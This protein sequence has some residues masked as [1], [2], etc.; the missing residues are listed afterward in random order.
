M[1]FREM[2]TWLVRRGGWPAATLALVLALAVGAPGFG[3]ASAPNPLWTERAAPVAPLPK[4]A[5]IWAEI[6]AAVMPA[7]V[8]VST[9]RRVE[10]RPAPE[11]RG[12]RDEQLEEFFERFFGRREGFPTP[13]PPREGRSLGSGFILHP[14]GY[15]VTNHH[16][17]DGAAAIR[18]T[19]GDGRELPATVVGRDPQT[20]LT[21]LRVEASD[22]PV[23]PLGES[24]RLRVGEPV[25]AIGNPFGLEQTVTTGIVSATGRVIGGGPYD[26]FIQT[27][28]SI[29]PG[30]SGGPLI[31]ARGEA[32]G[33]NSAIFSRTGGSVGIGFAIPVDLA[34]P[35]LTQLAEKGR[36][37]RSQLGV[38]IQQLT[39]DLARAFGVDAR[40]GA[41]VSSVAEGSPAERAGVKPGDVILEY[42][43]TEVGAWSTL[44]RLVAM[45]PPGRKVGLVVLRDGQ[46]VPLE[47]TVARMQDGEAPVAA[48]AE[49]T[50]RL[51]LSVQPVTPELAARLGLKDQRGVVVRSV[52]PDSPAA[53]AGLRPQDVI[54]E[55]NGK[56]VQ[57]IADL[58]G[59]LEASREGA[60]AVFL[61]R[62][63]SG[64]LFLAVPTA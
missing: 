24:S 39:P 60:S 29:N 43:G 55:V 3:V 40:E 25:M 19:L 45:T 21:L 38:T 13:R 22:L 52:E 5:M 26:D 42:D 62:R 48:K 15:I 61:V 36:V 33:I 57:D 28:A 59:A 63:E 10:A 34:K 12:P 32:V 37:E 6:A 18:V 23:V 27:D 51:G 9:T 50:G 30:N 31:N 4:E 53:R 14:D 1:R 64:N 54:I 49:E 41:L 47:A 17:V 58:T 2:K 16:V 20:D 8:N 46:R 44:P 35:I 7:V 11:R 56:P